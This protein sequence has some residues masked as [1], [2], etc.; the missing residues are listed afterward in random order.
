MKMDCITFAKKHNLDESYV[1]SVCMTYLPFDR[2]IDKSVSP[3]YIYEESKI[4]EAVKYD[5][6][7]TIAR[8]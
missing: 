6:S 7:K 2:Y 3:L 4:T 1:C 8:L 5:M